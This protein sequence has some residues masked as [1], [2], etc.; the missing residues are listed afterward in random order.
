MVQIF[1]FFGNILGYLL[2]FL[3][4]IV[5]NYGIAII[6]FTI[7]LKL[8]M[9]PFSINQQKSM[10]AQG[11][12]AAKQK[13]LQKKYADDKAKY[14][15]E[16]Q[17]LYQKEGMNPGAGCLTTLIPF[18][19]MLGL[20]YSVVF[21]IQN[22]LHY[23]TDVV[24]QATSILTKIPG[25]ASN[26]SGNTFYNEMQ[27]VKHFSELRPYL[28]MF[29]Q[30]QL[31][32]LDT[33]S[34]SFNLFGFD[35]LGTPQGSSFASLLWIIPVLCLVSAWLQQFYMNKT[36]PSMQQ[37]QGCMKGMM[38]MMPL[39]SVYFAY[40]MPAAIGFYWVISQLTGFLQTVI[41]QRFYGVDIM[42]AKQEAQRATLRFIEEEKIK[43]LSYEDQKLIE[44][45]LSFTGSSDN[46]GKSKNNQNKS[47]AKNK[48]AKNNTDNYLGKKK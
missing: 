9:F 36:N 31:S 47:A 48:A 7:V 1:N 2:K 4:L 34:K 27:V 5:Q 29:S 15:E 24:N 12:L 33:F 28:T 20:Y 18:P 32:E 44:S 37:Q 38:Y 3:Y 6:L 40:T 42:C 8:V 43:P 46:T 23:S 11:K 41:M 25:V 19:I 39:I 45:K 35:L 16:L 26:F 21:P 10:A 22:M 17:A 30:D 13:E 14:N